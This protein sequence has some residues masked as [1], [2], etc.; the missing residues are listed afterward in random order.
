MS[1]RVH[2]P[3]VEH[4]EAMGDDQL[5]ALR[6]ALI[7][8]QGQCEIAIADAKVEGNEDRRHRISLA[9]A[10][11]R[12]GLACIASIQAHRAGQ[13]MFRPARPVTDFASA[14]SA[15][16]AMARLLGLYNDLYLAVGVWLKLDTDDAADEVER[17]YRTVSE[18]MNPE[19][20]A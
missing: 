8:A 2:V 12:R 4:L 10:H 16:K 7:E 5:A 6:T 11:Y 17:I 18:A 14:V 9:L 19:V 15:S 3:K 1:E 13:P 20:A